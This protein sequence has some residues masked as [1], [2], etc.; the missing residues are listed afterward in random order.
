MNVSTVPPSRPALTSHYIDFTTGET[1]A[2]YTPPSSA[3]RT[4]ALQKY[5]SVAE[6]YEALMQP[7]FW[8]FPSP[9]NIP[10]DLLLPF[11][12]FVVKYNLTAAV[13]QIFE[14]TGFGVHDLMNSLTMWVMRSFNT[15]ICRTLLGIN[16]A[17]VPASHRNQELY[18]KILTLL[19]SDVLLSSTVISSSRSR[20][21]GGVTLQVRAP[22]GKLTRIHAKRLLVAIEPTAANLEPLNLD[23]QESST[24]DAFEYSTTFVGVVSHPS[25]PVN[26]SLVNTPAAAEPN[27]WIATIPASPLE[28]RFDYY[29][30]SGNFFRAIMVGDESLSA[31]EAQGLAYRALGNMLKAG[32]LPNTGAG[33]DQLRWHAFAAHGLVSAQ[34]S[35]DE[36]RS[37]FIQNLNALQGHRSTWYTGAAWSVHLTTSLWLFTETVLPKLVASL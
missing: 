26:G 18:D 27:N 29:G 12:S 31:Q 37:G 10:Q 30:G 3:D 14:T 20:T 33:A 36:L 9:H 2:S 13:Q 25:L 16:T 4:A 6:Q 35:A 22:S 17:F 7:G 5:L 1:L 24:F 32:S 8:N 34:V 15:D 19:G 23:D 21:G 11:G 28:A